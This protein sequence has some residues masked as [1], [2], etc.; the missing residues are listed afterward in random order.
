MLAFDE[1]GRWVRDASGE[2]ASAV[3]ALCRTECVGAGFSNR[4]FVA[5]VWSA[6]ASDATLLSVCDPCEASNRAALCIG[7]AVE[8]GGLRAV[9]DAIAREND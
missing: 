6:G 1:P 8:V 4:F 5:H 3:C 7:A 9:V 2:V